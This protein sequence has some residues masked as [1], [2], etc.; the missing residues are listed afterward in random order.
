MNCAQALCTAFHSISGSTPR[1]YDLPIAMGGR[2]Q[3]RRSLEEAL[4]TAWFVTP[5]VNKYPKK[6]VQ[7]LKEYLRKNH[8]V[9]P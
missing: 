5:Q 6:K 4:S 1:L 2:P 8:Y 3:V 9:I 7:L